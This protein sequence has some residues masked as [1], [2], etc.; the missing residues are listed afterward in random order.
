MPT[1]TPSKPTLL[2]RIVETIGELPA[3]PTVVSSIMGLTNDLNTDLNQLSR[4]LSADQSLTAKVLRLSNSPFYGRMRGVAT[5]EEAIM[6]LGFFT[7]R[8]LVVASSAYSMFNKNGKGNLESRL[9]NHS[10][11]AAMGARLVARRAGSKHIEEAFLAGLLHDIGSLIMVKK[12]R[13]E[14]DAVLAEAN[15]SNLDLADVERERLGFSH[16]ELGSLILEKWNF[17]PILS[18]AVHHHHRP[19]A[20]SESGAPAVDSETLLATHVV[21]F[22]D[23]LAKSLGHGICDTQ[24]DDITTLPSARYLHLSP[25]MIADAAEELEERFAEELK[26][27]AD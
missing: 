24:S 15:E 1:L 25:E 7:I 18:L 11:A 3:S 10:L 22:A 2:D 26:L 21:C 4:V 14:Y 17:P 9:W 20:L 8:S 6:I 19:E 5:L 13:K 12:M 27:F 23:A 16:E